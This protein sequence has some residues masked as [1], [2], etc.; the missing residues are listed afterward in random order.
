MENIVVARNKKAFHDY[1]IIDRFEAGI[2][3]VGSEVKSLRENKVHLKESY[4]IV[5]NR[6][7]FLIGMHIGPYSHTGYTTHEPRRKRR[8]LLHMKEINKLHNSA[9]QKGHTIVPLQIYFSSKGFAKMEIALAKG[10]QQYAKKE[11][12]K[13]RDIERDTAREMSRRR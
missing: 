6:E 13:A 1:R 9:T 11:M 12:I 3:L 5:Q 10:K 4:V 8:L 2:E 7:V